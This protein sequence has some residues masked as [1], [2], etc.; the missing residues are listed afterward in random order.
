MTQTNAKQAAKTTLTPED[1]GK[2]IAGL[3]LLDLRIR[4]GSHR[5]SNE[6]YSAKHQFSIHTDIEASFAPLGTDLF[7]AEQVF[8]LK[9]RGKGSK[10]I[11][12]SV[13]CLIVALYKSKSVQINEAL[14][15]AFKRGTLLLNTWPF[16][17]EFTHSCTLRA[18]LPPL[19]LP[20]AKFLP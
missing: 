14:F 1:W 11:L 4:E 6:L 16:I 3:D 8:T 10:R 9:I 15:D 5:F 12:G 19:V 17:R 2:F 13:K 18:G 7:E 20:L